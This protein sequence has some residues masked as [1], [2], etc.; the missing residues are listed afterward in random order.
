MYPNSIRAIQ[1]HWLLPPYKR[2]QGANQLRFAHPSFDGYGTSAMSYSSESKVMS[3][4]PYGGTG[5][6]F[7]K[8]YAKC[9]KPLIGISHERVTALELQTDNE[10]IIVINCYFPFH[11][12]R[13]IEN[14]TAMYRET[15]GFVDNILH[16][17][18]DS[19]CIILADFNCDITD[20]NHRYSQLLHPLMTKYQ[21]TSAFELDSNFDY[22]SSYTRFDH[23]TKSYTLI[24]G[25]LISKGLKSKVKRICISQYGDNVSDHIPVELDLELQI[26]E[27]I[28]ANKRIPLYVNWCKL[29][30]ENKRRFKDEMTKALN[31]IQIPSLDIFHGI[32]CCQND[33]HKVSL[34]RYFLDIA[35]AVSQ[36]ESVL[37]RSNPNFQRSFW[38]DDLMN[39]KQT[40]IDCNNHWKSFGCPR[41]GPIFECR[42]KCHYAYKAAVRKSK[43]EDDRKTKENLYLDLVNK[44]GINFW[45]QWNVLNRV[46]NNIS[47]RINGE[48]DEKKIANEFATYFES[49]YSGSD[50]P[51]YS[52]LK[53]KFEQEY[54]QYFVEHINDDISPFYASWSDMIE[55]AKKIEIGKAS[56]GML[57]P[58]HF[59]FGSPH[60][61][62]HFQILFNGM[63]QHSYV[64]SEFLK[65][66]ITP[67]VKDSQGDITTPSNYRGITL[68]CLPAKLFECLIQSKTSHLLG[69][70]DLQFGF[71]SRT[72]SSHA[73]F[74]LNS[75]I[76]Y[77]NKKGS[78]VYA[79]FLDCTK[80]FDRI[81]HHGLFSKLIGRQLPLCILLCLV[82]W[83]TNM[84]CCVK[85]GSETSQSFDI[86]MGIKQGGINSPGY[87]GVYMNE[88]SK[89]LRENRI[90]CHVY[91][92]FLAMIL[93]ADDIS[94]LAPTRSAL[95]KLIKLCSDYCNSMGITFNPLKSKIL[96]FSKSKI[97]HNDFQSIAL[98][99]SNIEYC[100]SVKYLGVSIVTEKSLCFSAANDLRKFY[101]A[102]NSLLSVIQR[103]SEEVCMHLLYTNCIPVLTYACNVKEFSAKEM[104]D[105]NTA[106]NNAI[107]KIFSFNRWES[108][109]ALREGCGYKSIYDIFANARQKFNDSLISHSNPILRF[110]HRIATLE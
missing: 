53:Q 107:R 65:G 15:I 16:Q 108:V 5:F 18:R 6:V 14:Y 110:L 1:E 42:Q 38:N 27:S 52:Q 75:T 57:R 95:Q 79:A 80:A 2:Q 66:V 21:L 84:S 8:K 29:T 96:V 17:N 44:N 37:P 22:A 104:R 4:R 46:G 50:G 48:T 97:N 33:D 35:A 70:D 9:L 91:K 3:G 89:L 28:P 63:L 109:R 10:K 74:A 59:I 30:D 11:N 61:L 82:Y 20:A 62:R 41:S 93:F 7:H 99:N 103:P 100:D 106:I 85:W 94:L 105:I 102:T 51:V 55:I 60:L 67:I 73:L 49:V 32:H 54:N 43:A 47:S 101:R 78:K 87:F 98:D 56:F 69:T 39:L 13:D 68:S 92:Q 19:E 86:P 64:P 34:E 83:Y 76:E 24:D 90:G 71:K 77:F 25:I 26:S 23:K 88:L 36:A 58:E 31:E 81:S 12:L 72:S 40:S 45:K